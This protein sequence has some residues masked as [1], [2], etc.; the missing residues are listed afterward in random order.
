[1][2]AAPVRAS[3]A[4]ASWS[5]F[6]SPQR[7]WDAAG[8]PW[9]RAASMTSPPPTTPPPVS[10]A[11]PTTTLS[12]PSLV[13]HSLSLAPTSPPAPP[14]SARV[15]STGKAG[16][17]GTSALGPPPVSLTRAGALRL[18]WRVAA[19]CD[20]REGVAR[21]PFPQMAIARPMNTSG[22]VK[23]MGGTV[24]YSPGDGCVIRTE[25]RQLPTRV[26]A[27]SRL[28]LPPGTVRTETAASKASTTGARPQRCPVRRVTTR[29]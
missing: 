12:S 9:I 26:P 28:S 24:Q 21:S 5:A 6:L 4:A 13:W 16:R 27:S 8:R 2:A 22:Q 1:V 25:W 11:P 3:P 14:P 29:S 18:P 20:R 15:E 23:R 10:E 7:C 17:G 19:R